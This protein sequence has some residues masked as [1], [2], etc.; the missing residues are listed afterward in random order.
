MRKILILMALIVPMFVSCASLN[1]K[2]GERYELEQSENDDVEAYYKN[3]VDE[4]GFD[5]AKEIATL[6]LAGIS[7]RCELM[8]T[9]NVYGIVSDSELSDACKVLKKYGEQYNI[10]FIGVHYDE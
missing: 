7:E 10:T 3:L 1:E 2:L 4:Y 5:K 8:Y 6:E 9:Q